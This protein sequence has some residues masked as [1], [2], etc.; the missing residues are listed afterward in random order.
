[1]FLLGWRLGLD[2][3]LDIFSVGP[4]RVDGTLTRR[5]FRQQVVTRFLPP[6]FN[7]PL[8]GNT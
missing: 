1:M 6:G 7:C 5:W 4:R 3:L 8:L 2:R